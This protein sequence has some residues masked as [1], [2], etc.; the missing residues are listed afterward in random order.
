[1]TEA[2]QG[3]KDGAAVDETQRVHACGAE[4]PE[5]SRMAVMK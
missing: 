2:Y 5:S 4:R 3:A 1:M